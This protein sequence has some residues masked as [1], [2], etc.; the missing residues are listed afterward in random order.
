MAN[1][2][3][4]NSILYSHFLYKNFAY[5]SNN[6]DDLIIIILYSVTYITSITVNILLLLLYITIITIKY[7]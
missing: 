3:R 2:N 7:Y 1:L 6:M 4:S 5:N